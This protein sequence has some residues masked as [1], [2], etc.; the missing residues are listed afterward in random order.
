MI[1]KVNSI[2]M[3]MGISLNHHGGYRRV[4]NILLGGA[5]VHLHNLLQKTIFSEYSEDDKIKIVD[6][7]SIATKYIQC[8]IFFKFQTKQYFSYQLVSCLQTKLFIA[9]S[10]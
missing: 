10:L 1:R 6:P 7:V 9:L 2:S 8:L 5:Q 3:G 4:G